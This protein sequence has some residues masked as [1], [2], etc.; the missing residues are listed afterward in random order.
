MDGGFGGSDSRAYG[1]NSR[2]HSSN[3]EIYICRNFLAK[4]FIWCMLEPY[5]SV[6]PWDP[7]YNNFAA[8]A[9]CNANNS[10]YMCPNW[11]CSGCGNCCTQGVC[12]GITVDYGNV[13]QTCG[14][15]WYRTSLY[16]NGSVQY[17]C[18]GFCGHDNCIPKYHRWDCFWD[19]TGVCPMCHCYAANGLFS[20]CTGGFTACSYITSTEATLQQCFSGYNVS[21]LRTFCYGCWCNNYTFNDHYNYSVLQGIGYYP[22]NLGGHSNGTACMFCQNTG[23]GCNRSEQCTDLGSRLG[24]CNSFGWTCFGCHG[25]ICINSGMCPLICCCALHTCAGVGFGGI[26]CTITDR[27][28]IC[29]S[30][31][32][33]SALPFHTTPTNN[34]MD[35][36]GVYLV[37]WA[38]NMATA[39]ACML[40]G[41]SGCGTMWECACGQPGMGSWWLC[42]YGCDRGFSFGPCCT[43]GNGFCQ[44]FPNC[45]SSSCNCFGNYFYMCMCFRNYFSRGVNGGYCSDF[46]YSWCDAWAPRYRW[47]FTCCVPYGSYSAVPNWWFNPE[48]DYRGMSTN[49]HCCNCVACGSQGCVGCPSGNWALAVPGSLVCIL[50]ANNAGYCGSTMC[51]CAYSSC[52]ACN[53]S[54]P[55]TPGPGIFDTWCC[56]QNN[57]VARL[58]NFPGASA[59]NY[60][61]DGPSIWQCVIPRACKFSANQTQ[62]FRAS[63]G[64]TWYKVQNFL[65][66]YLCTGLQRYD[67]SA[68]THTLYGVPDYFQTTTTFVPWSG[69]RSANTPCGIVDL[70]G[71]WCSRCFLCDV[72][73]CGYICPSFG[74]SNFTPNTCKCSDGRYYWCRLRCDPYCVEDTWRLCTQSQGSNGP[75]MCIPYASQYQCYFYQC[76]TYCPGGPSCFRDVVHCNQKN[77]FNAGP[78][79]DC[80]VWEHIC[81]VSKTANALYCI[82]GLYCCDYRNAQDIQAG[83]ARLGDHTIP[84]NW[85]FGCNDNMILCACPGLNCMANFANNDVLCFD[86]QPVRM[87]FNG[88]CVGSAFGSF[89]GSTYLCSCHSSGCWLTPNFF[90]KN[91]CCA[92]HRILGANTAAEPQRWPV[93][94]CGCGGCSCYGMCAICCGPSCWC[95]GHNMG[96][97]CVMNTWWINTSPAVFWGCNC[98]GDTNG[99]GNC[100]AC[101]GSG[102][103]IPCRFCNNYMPCY[104]SAAT[105]QCCGIPFGNDKWRPI[106]FSACTSGCDCWN[107]FNKNPYLSLWWLFKYDNDTHCGGS[108]CGF[109]NGGFFTCGMST[110]FTMALMNYLT[111]PV[112]NNS[113]FLNNCHCNGSNVCGN[114]AVCG[115]WSPIDPGTWGIHPPG[116]CRNAVL[117][118]GQKG[119]R[120][121]WATNMHVFRSTNLIAH[122]R[123]CTFCVLN[124]TV[125]CCCF[126]NSYYAKPRLDKSMREGPEDQRWIIAALSLNNCCFGQPFTCCPGPGLNT[127]GCFPCNSW[128]GSG[129]CTCGAIEQYCCQ[130]RLFHKTQAQLGRDYM[131]CT[132][133]MPRNC[134]CAS[135]TNDY[136]WLPCHCQWSRAAWNTECMIFCTGSVGGGPKRGRMQT[137]LIQD[138]DVR[139]VCGPGTGHTM[140]GPLNKPFWTCSCKTGMCFN[141]PCDPSAWSANTI[142]SPAGDSNI[143]CG[144][145]DTRQIIGGGAWGCIGVSCT[146]KMETCTYPCWNNCSVGACSA[147]LYSVWAGPICYINCYTMAPPVTCTAAYCDTGVCGCQFNSPGPN[148]NLNFCSCNYQVGAGAGVMIPCL[149]NIFCYPYTTHPG[150]GGGG[151]F[152]C[153]NSVGCKTG[154]GGVLASA[155]GADSYT[156]FCFQSG[157]GAGAGWNGIPGTGMAIIYW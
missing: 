128:P 142:L 21:R 6:P 155:A 20:A 131:Y 60:F 11:V 94:T 82:M 80:L 147:C 58:H 3:Q 111:N 140:F 102:C 18:R 110:G 24:G 22:L 70:C 50:S 103:L 115:V 30:H 28:F 47:A 12:A 91:C 108:V 32:F 73:S 64:G 14:I 48:T 137:T 43:P 2:I 35:C 95:T 37:N 81:C 15:P 66:W 135:V 31:C 51:N 143:G 59:G 40:C 56:S 139:V 39:I 149:V 55:G 151:M 134:M 123:N 62:G 4:P 16:W 68:N 132:Y 124:S 107:C 99:W 97:E 144:W 146:T 52:C 120:G 127:R 9:A 117:G 116:G 112:T 119:A 19:K 33:M 96:F 36:P 113:F 41:N 72:D 145:F 10:V 87:C 84:T 85:I 79:M 75:C 86:V 133:F 114:S 92:I 93:T 153:C 53:G 29:C 27:M 38:P 44:C 118:A 157:K 34:M 100:S 54:Y 77:F 156:N 57:R 129:T 69:A 76:A 23:P 45:D 150:P 5:Q 74:W 130:F 88:C 7:Y 61:N 98:A 101:V 152:G 65:C 26:L 78:I 126:F 125:M 17:Q 25:G 49:V 42:N 13:Y 46:G 71:T 136:D 138:D 109:K 104:N 90:W 106:T 1:R 154:C 122:S 89:C 67:P 8:S 105:C 141:M 83:P 63:G 121:F 148:G